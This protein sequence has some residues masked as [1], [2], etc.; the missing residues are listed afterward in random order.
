[1]TTFTPTFVL[2]IQGSASGY[3]SLPL[4]SLAHDLIYEICGWFENALSTA[5]LGGVKQRASPLITPIL[6]ISTQCA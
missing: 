2:L 1:M 3:A 6:Q 4:I 5:V